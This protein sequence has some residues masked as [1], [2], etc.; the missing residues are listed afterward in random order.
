[1]LIKTIY[2]DNPLR[3]FNYLIA[4]S[5]T[6][7]ALA[8]DPLA[9]DE[10]LMAAKIAGWEITQVLNTHEHQDH[11]AGNPEVVA[12]TGA[13]VLAHH[14][15]AKVIKD[16]DVGLNAGDVI[17]VGKTVELEV[18][19]TPGHTFC[20][21]CLLAHG[22]EA[23]IFSG[24]TLFNAGC[25]NCHNGGD[26]KTL[27]NT[28]MEQLYRLPPQTRVYPGHDYLVNNLEFSLSREPNNEQAKELLEECKTHHD[29]FAPMVTTLATEAEINP[30]FRLSSPEVIAKLREV[31]PQLSAH[32]TDEEVFVALRG[33]RD[34]W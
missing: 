26:A 25:G 24:D 27:Y 9:A 10:C 23:A 31:A 29:P 20:H 33:C 28:F 32:P 4:C 8:V 21:V 13:K 18:L 30:F 34:S 22:D 1:M 3:N 7:E 16:V 5:E 6:G 19:D 14:Q 11:T 15:A 2:T 12:A 17:K